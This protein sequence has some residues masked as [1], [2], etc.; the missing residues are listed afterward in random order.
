MVKH[1]IQAT[2]VIKENHYVEASTPEEAFAKVR[3][4]MQEK[5]SENAL[6]EGSVDGQVM[7]TDQITV[8]WGIDDVASQRSGLTDDQCRE[9]LA[10]VKQDH[11]SNEG[12]NWDVIDIAIDRMFPDVP[13]ET[14]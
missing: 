14:E 2:A 5:Y 13:A 11:D 1:F 12:I 8:G 7:P 10:S 4:L 3:K 6:V 9:V